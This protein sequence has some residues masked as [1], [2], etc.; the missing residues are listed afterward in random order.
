MIVP[1]NAVLANFKK[2]ARFGY[3]QELPFVIEWSERGLG[4]ATKGNVGLLTVRFPRRLT[5][6][7]VESRRRR[8]RKAL[9]FSTS[10]IFGVE[11]KRIRETRSGVR[12]LAFRIDHS[13]CFSPRFRGGAPTCRRSDK[14]RA[15]L[16][17]ERIGVRT[18]R[19]DETTIALKGSKNEEDVSYRRVCRE[20]DLSNGSR[21][22]RGTSPNPRVAAR[23][24]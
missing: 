1:F 18:K 5:V 19:L 15:P 21:F 11:I 16:R 7:R 23:K 10:G 8:G 6:E 22:T 2:T 24:P 3:F 12:A 17:Y 4:N 20:N 13:S 9:A 14:E